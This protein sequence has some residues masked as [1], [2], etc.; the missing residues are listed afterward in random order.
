MKTYN[1]IAGTTSSE[2]SIGEGAVSVRQMVFGAV[3][4]GADS[5]ALDRNGNQLSVVG[6][7]FYELKLFGTDNLG[8]RVTKQ[9]RGTITVG[10]GITKIEDTFEEG[11]N[12]AIA[13]TL[14]ANT[15]TMSCKIGSATSA[16]YSIY[17][18][19]QRIE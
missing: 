12:G 14:N 2:F 9:L 10:S 3:C 11:F 5:N 18:A 8:N 1:N 6:T 17:I 19:L 16:T 15:V 13:L 4:V 7:E